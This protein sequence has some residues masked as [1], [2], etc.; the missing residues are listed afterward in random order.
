MVERFGL[1]NVFAVTI[2]ADEV[3]TGKPEPEGYLAGAAALG[4]APERCVVIEDALPG[5]RAAQAA[6]MELVVVDRLNRPERF[7][8]IV[9]VTRLDDGVLGRMLR[10]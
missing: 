2:S 4:V 3:T 6:G 5:I 10:T 8:P 9:P 7:V 1:A